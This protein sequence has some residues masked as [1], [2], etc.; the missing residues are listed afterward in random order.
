M[1]VLKLEEAWKVRLDVYK[2][3]L[4]N[5]IYL[6]ESEAEVKEKIMTNMYT[7]PEP[8]RVEDP[9]HIEGNMVFTYLDAF[10]KPEHFAEYLPDYSDLDELKAHYMLSLI[11]IFCTRHSVQEAPDDFPIQRFFPYPLP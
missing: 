7:D 10:C 2:R 4:G 6:S 1:E 9:G 11:H 5:C 8:I 3:Q